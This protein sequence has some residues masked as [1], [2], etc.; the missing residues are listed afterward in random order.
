MK[1]M[2]KTEYMRELARLR[3]WTSRPVVAVSAREEARLY[4]DPLFVPS[5]QI[6]CGGPFQQG[7]FGFCRGVRYRRFTRK[8]DR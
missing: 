5:E 8:G 7:E 2:T 4:K 1:Y 6:L 3:E